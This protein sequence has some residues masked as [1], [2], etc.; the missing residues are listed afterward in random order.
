MKLHCTDNVLLL[1][2][3]S[4][5]ASL[6]ALI[7]PGKRGEHL[8]ASKVVIQICLLEDL[9]EWRVQLWRHLRVDKH[10]QKGVTVFHVCHSP[11]RRGVPG[12][13]GMQTMA[14]GIIARVII[15][16][17]CIVAIG[18]VPVLDEGHEVV[19]PASR[20]SCWPPAHDSVHVD[21]FASLESK[22][23]KS[24]EIKL[25]LANVFYRE[26][27]V[28][29]E[30]CVWADQD[31]KVPGRE[32]SK[33][34]VHL[35]VQAHSWKGVESNRVGSRRRMPLCKVVLDLGGRGF[36]LEL[37]PPTSIL[38]PP[39]MLQHWAELRH[40][41]ERRL[42]PSVANKALEFK[43]LG[44]DVLQCLSPYSIREL[45]QGGTNVSHYRFEDQPGMS[46]ERVLGFHLLH[47]LIVLVPQRLAHGAVDS[48]E[49]HNQAV[50]A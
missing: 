47:G 34:L 7:S 39:G 16:A 13:L 43:V 11:F 2:V 8:E 9:W 4:I 18:I 1:A 38:L 23:A 29:E 25:F 10:G 36:M 27:R 31:L 15:D 22:T 45:V 24:V 21:K 32:L 50:D 40:G 14:I 20:A 42:H 37:A 49:K 35:D 6:L 19:G 48:F 41:P 30:R 44:C 12:Y 46:H 3:A 5:S 28:K 26:C 33:Q 17:N